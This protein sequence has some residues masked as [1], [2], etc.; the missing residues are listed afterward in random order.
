[1][2]TTPVLTQLKIQSLKKISAI[3]L[4]VAAVAILPMLSGCLLTS[5]F[6]N[7]AFS[8]RADKIPIQAYT[9]SNATQVKFECA[10]AGHYGLYPVGGPV[11]WLPV[12]NVTPGG[13][14][15]DTQGNVVYSAGLNMTLPAACWNGDAAYSPVKWFTAIR[16]TQLI[17]GSTQE[18]KTFTKTGLACLGKENGLTATWFG[19]IGKN[20][21]AT[22]S[23]S[24]TEI[25]FV[26]INA[27]S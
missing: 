12:A 10:K 21:T 23:G 19:W 25:P 11:V 8:S 20:C 18:Y 14:S 3:T 17:S 1:V 13:A 6:W 16:A 24:T 7:Q 2:K 15:Y 26:I 22:Y 5:P 9:T 4:R 27:A